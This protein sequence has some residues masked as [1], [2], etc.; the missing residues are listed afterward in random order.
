MHFLITTGPTREY[1]DDVRFLTNGSS[2]KMGVAVATQAIQAGHTAT[3]LAGPMEPSLL[4]DAQAAGAKVVSFIS[5]ADL[6]AAM[7]D[8]FPACDV[9]VMAAAVGDFTV[10]RKAAKMSRKAGSITLA[11]EPT[12]DVLAGISKTRR[13]NQRIVAFA[14]ETGTESEMETKARAELSAKGADVVVL[15]TPAAMGADDSLACILDA[16]ATVLPWANRSK[17]QLAEH[18]VEVV[19]SS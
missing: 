15:N 10:P 2:G 19:A 1:L 14:V 7:A 16:K 11:L 18:I 12:I 5:V 6:Q 9:L 8:H 17:H 3:L 4:A 13:L